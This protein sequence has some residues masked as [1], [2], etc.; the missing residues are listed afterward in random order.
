MG[1]PQYFCLLKEHLLLQMQTQWSQSNMELNG[2]EPREIDS[3]CFPVSK[4][5]GK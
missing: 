3:R 5:E 2:L 1:Q 4:P